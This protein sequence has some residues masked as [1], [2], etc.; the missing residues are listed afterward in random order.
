MDGGSWN[1]GSSAGYF[2]IGRS[3]NRTNDVGS[4][5]CL[6]TFHA[7]EMATWRDFF[8]DMV[9]VVGCVLAFLSVVLLI[10]LMNELYGII[11]ALLTLIIVL[12][13]FLP[14]GPSGTNRK[15]GNN[16]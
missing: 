8:R 11:P 9:N 15:G 6:P 5:Y 4:R 10:M 1:H 3:E 14:P 2:S 16:L 7:T 13:V 12:L